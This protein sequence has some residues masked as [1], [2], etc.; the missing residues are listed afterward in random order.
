MQLSRFGQKVASDAGI[1][2]LMDD[3]GDALRVNPEMIF[4]GGGNPASIPEVEAALSSALQGVMDDPGV[5][6]PMLGVYQPPQG[7]PEFLDSL[8]RELRRS[9]GW[10]VTRANL[11]VANGSQSAFFVLFNLLAGEG[12]DG[13]Y[14]RVQLPLVPEYLGYSDVGLAPALFRANRPAIEM[15]P[16]GLFKYHIDFDRLELGEDTGAL[17]LSRPTNPTGNMVTDDELGR[18]DGLARA[19]DI[20]LILD[21]AYGAPFPNI[22]YQPT[23][24]FWNDNTILVMSLSKLGLPGARTGI[25][26][27]NPE[28]IQAFARANTV[29]SLASGN[30]G[31]ALAQQL[32]VRGE[33]FRL[34]PEVIQ[35]F[36]R[37]R[38]QAALAVF[39]RELAGLPVRI[40]RPEGAFFLWLW[41]EGLPISTMAL[42]ERLK[43]R[44]VLVVPGEH[45]FP[46]LEEDWDHRHECLRVTYC[47]A[48]ERVEQGAKI[49]GD[50]VRRLYKDGA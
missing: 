43:V 11:A 22:S 42:Y 3:L 1:V 17:C 46:G 9:C 6:R 45:F 50:E 14:R 39:Q 32:L 24:P 19:Q 30:L 5:R 34:G 13:V 4:M 33:L 35:P 48:P 36:Y 44:G 15:L 29:L 41:F 49:L 26:L 27:A 25:V 23:L 40:H 12:S 21:V 7:D 37:H 18:L 2:T 10:P 47:Q 20:P 8:A 28:V 16:E 31:P 38:M